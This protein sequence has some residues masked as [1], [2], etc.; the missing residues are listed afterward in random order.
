MYNEHKYQSI[1]AG[2]TAL[3]HLNPNISETKASVL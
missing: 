1:T 3:K 2:L